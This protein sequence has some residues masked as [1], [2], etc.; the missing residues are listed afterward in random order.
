MDFN[1]FLALTPIFIII[2]LLILRR[3]LFVSAPI[4]FF[5]T[6]IIAWFVWKMNPAYIIGSSTKGLFVAID[7]SLIIFGAIFFL[8][9]LKNTK[10]LN[11]IICY[12][13][14]VSSDR[15]VQVII[16]V[17][18]LGS[19]IEG[20]AGFGTPAAIIAP[21]LV[22]I[23]F[24]A[25]TAVVLALVGNSTAV[26]FGAAGTPIRV[27]LSGIQS[28]GVVTNVAMLNGIAGFLVPLFLVGLLILNESQL[29]N[30]FNYFLEIIPFALWSGFVLLVPYY[31]SSFIGQE[32]P[33]LMGSIVG[34]MIIIITTKRGFFTPKNIWKIKERKHLNQTDKI[35][36]KA[37]IPYLILIILLMTGKYVLPSFTIIIFEEIKHSFNLFN[38]G[39]LFV[40]TI[41]VVSML[42]SVS[43]KVVLDSAYSAV[44]KLLYPFISILFITA[45][46]QIMIYSNYNFS[47]LSSMINIIATMFRSQS[48]LFFSPFIG[49]FGAFIAGSA[50]VSTLLFASFQYSAGVDLGLNVGVLLA[51]QVVGAG[52][53][54]MIALTNIVA[55]EA[56]V[57]LHNQ[58][59]E[60][61]KRTFIPCMI[62][63][64]VV[65]LIAYLLF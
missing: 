49:A 22:G 56:T 50:T 27:G 64:V 6:F 46:V 21:L 39:L 26:A 23:G 47:G 35:S 45:F 7:I 24:P 16:L 8:E 13:E 59:F 43:R 1:I 10:L 51:L 12:L 36:F 61:F 11:S 25:L 52:V 28:E 18:F 2:I 58:E 55:A 9:F 37:I 57:K 17:W 62:Y 30:K 53:G 40:V 38:P 48:I 44:S 41:V 20:I 33:S 19:F 5:V 3:P 14:S 4:T 31:L 65:S 54:N 34:L 32:F 42:F 15:R 63:L 60:I 29:K